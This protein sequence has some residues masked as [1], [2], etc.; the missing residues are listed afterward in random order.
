MLSICPQAQCVIVEQT[1][2][3]IIAEFLGEVEAEPAIV[4]DL[5]A[6]TEVTL[7]VD[8]LDGAPGTLVLDIN[9]IGFPVEILGAEQ[10]LVSVRIPSVGLTEAQLGKLYVLNADQQLVSAIDARLHPAAQ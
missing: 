1:T 3:V 6:D 9:G 2:E 10:G 4:I 8:G 5:E 7:E